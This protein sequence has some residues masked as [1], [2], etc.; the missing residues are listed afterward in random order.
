MSENKRKN[1][2]AVCLYCGESVIYDT[3]EVTDMAAAHKVLIE[4]DQACVK[5]PVVRERDRLSAELTALKKMLNSDPAMR[6]RDVVLEEAAQ[7]IEGN[8]IC[9]NGGEGKYFA[10]REHG[11]VDGLFYADALRSMKTQTLVNVH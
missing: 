11:N 2:A 10:P 6:V 1:K 4:H 3:S 7:V 9:D 8:H 5:N